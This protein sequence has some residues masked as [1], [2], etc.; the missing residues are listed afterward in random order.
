MSLEPKFARSPEGDFIFSL[1][2]IFDIQASVGNTQINNFDIHGANALLNIISSAT[3]FSNAGISSA[4]A[5]LRGEGVKQVFVDPLVDSVTNQ[6]Q[7]ILLTDYALN[8]P[9][10]IDDLINQVVHNEVNK[11]QSGINQNLEIA[12]AS[13]RTKINQ[14]LN[15][16]SNGVLYYVLG[17][18]LKPKAVTNYHIGI[19]NPQ[20]ICTKSGYVYAN[21]VCGSEGIGRMAYSAQQFCGACGISVYTTSYYS[22]GTCAQITC[23]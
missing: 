20:A 1:K 3:S 5:L 7:S 8:N 14:A 22:G 6:L 19:I 16:D 21:T 10:H 17:P 4:E 9:L 18:D 15:L 13:A 2:P 23:K 11:I 12:T